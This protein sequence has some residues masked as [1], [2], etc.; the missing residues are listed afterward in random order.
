[1]NDNMNNENLCE[2]CG[3]PF[4]AVGG[5]HYYDGYATEYGYPMNACIRAGNPSCKAMAVIPSLTVET[6]DG[7]TNLYNCFVH[8]SNINTTFYVDDKHRPTLVWQGDVE[9]ETYDVENN[10]LGLREQDLYTTLND[11]Y[12]LVR[13]DRQGI[14]HIM[15]KEA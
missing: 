14:A 7:I 1:M 8:V 15:A 4:N 3:R 9:I 6:A 12:T 5:C 2:T 10:P 11:K 13:F